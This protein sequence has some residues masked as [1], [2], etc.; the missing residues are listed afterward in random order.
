VAVG[1]IH[2]IALP[3][4]NGHEQAGR[5]PAVLL[6]DDAYAGTLPVVFAVP[7]T[8]SLATR[9]FAGTVLIPATAQNGLSQDSV[10]LVFQ[11]RAVDR[12]RLGDRIGEVEDA[13]LTDI[14][15]ELDKLMGR[16]KTP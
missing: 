1:D 16:G 10:C 14:F 5:R 7:L 6:E 13:I 4:A 12:R 11:L 15:A 2:W 8:T 3:K 9:R